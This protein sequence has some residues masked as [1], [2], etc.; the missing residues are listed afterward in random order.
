MIRE[1]REMFKTTC[2]NEAKNKRE[3]FECLEGS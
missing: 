1:M 3:G 2:K